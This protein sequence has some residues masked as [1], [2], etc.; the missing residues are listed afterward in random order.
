[1]NKVLRVMRETGGKGATGWK[2]DGSRSE[3]SGTSNQEL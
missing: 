3:V 2:D 1:M